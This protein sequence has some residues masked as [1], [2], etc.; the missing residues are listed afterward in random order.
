MTKTVS[1]SH[2][3]ISRYANPKITTYVQAGENVRIPPYVQHM[4][5]SMAW[6]NESMEKLHLSMHLSIHP[7]IHSFH[8]IGEKKARNYAIYRV[9]PFYEV[10]L[11][12]V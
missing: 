12:Y 1:P 5:V 6:F 9:S 7:F 10:R 4:Y 11:T 2:L 8:E 3:Q